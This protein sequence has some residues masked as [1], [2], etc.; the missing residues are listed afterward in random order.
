YPLLSLKLPVGGNIVRHLQRAQVLSLIVSQGEVFDVDHLSADIDPEGGPRSLA[1]PEILDDL[2]HYVCAGRRMAV[3]HIPV[4]D[5]PVPLED[6]L[7]ALREI[8]YLVIAVDEGHVYRQ[9]V[10]YGQQL[11]NC[12]AARG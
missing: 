6:P 5:G 2:I 9:P 7:F 1:R 3:P 12:E 4:Q 10:K 11:F 8:L